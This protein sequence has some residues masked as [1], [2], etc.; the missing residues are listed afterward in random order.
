MPPSLLS[1]IIR[2]NGQPEASCGLRCP[3][4]SVQAYLLKITLHVHATLPL[5]VSIQNIFHQ[6]DVSHCQW[7]FFKILFCV[8]GIG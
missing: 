5:L 7:H 8:R 6:R 3:A 4:Y 2:E 1:S